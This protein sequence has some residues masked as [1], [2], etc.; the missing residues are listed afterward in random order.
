M[1]GGREPVSMLSSEK[2][3]GSFSLHWGRMSKEEAES[4]PVP[5][6]PSPREWAPLLL[7]GHK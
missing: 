2:K 3:S 6:P 4:P 7:W 1:D 5:R